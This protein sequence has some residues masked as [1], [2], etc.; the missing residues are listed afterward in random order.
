[1]NIYLFGPHDHLFGTI[2][3]TPASD[4]QPLT[5]QLKPLLEF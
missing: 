4:L 3:N 5:Q 1:L 2:V